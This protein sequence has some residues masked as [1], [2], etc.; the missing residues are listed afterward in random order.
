MQPLCTVRRDT[1]QSQS[2]GARTDIL[3]FIDR[4]TV[5]VPVY[6][7]TVLLFLDHGELGLIGFRVI[8]IGI[9]I[10]PSGKQSASGK[11]KIII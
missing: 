5:V 10:V 1:V 11:Q 4:T 3:D 7:S 9:N 8:D 2:T 6:R